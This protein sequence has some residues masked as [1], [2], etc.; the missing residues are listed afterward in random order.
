MKIEV[1]EY[2][3]KS[4]PGHGTRVTKKR[5]ILCKICNATT[6]IR[7]P[8]K[9]NNVK[10]CA[11]CVCVCTVQLILLLTLL[12]LL[13]PSLLL[14]C[15]LYFAYF[16]SNKISHTITLRE[17]T[18]DGTFT[19]APK[20]N[21]SRMKKKTLLTILRLLLKRHMCSNDKQ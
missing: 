14:F 3:G 6:L 1:M 16:L 20:T 5:K 7:K 4:A 15:I 10:V 2:N 11:E 13:P 19:K 17:C 8:S 18:M 9:V 12:L 21:R